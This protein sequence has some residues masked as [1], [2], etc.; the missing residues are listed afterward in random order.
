MIIA[1]Q[2]ALAALE[3]LSAHTDHPVALHE[4]AARLG[5]SASNCARIL[6]T[7]VE[8]GY[9]EQVGR[10]KGY[11]LG[12]VAYA[13]ARHGPYRKDLV[14]AA[15]PFVLGLASALRETASLAVLR[16]GR[17]VL[18]TECDGGQEVQ[19]RGAPGQN[20]DPYLT[21]G[22]RLLL[23]HLAEGDLQAFLAQAGLPAREL[24]PEA[25]R[26]DGLRRCLADIRAAGLA[27]RVRPEVVGLAVPVNDDTGVCA[28]LGVFLPAYRF[29]EE[30]RQEVLVRIRRAAQ[31]LSGHL[32]ARK[33]AL[34]R[35]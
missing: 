1:V 17:R 24:W 33:P 6:Q 23:A 14:V 13:L 22:G 3:V 31:E 15:E 9:A 34:V 5:L 20:Y 11:I 29:I 7:L 27:M 25:A 18:L 32:Q 8:T 26:E 4:L 28:A 21:A 10:K 19:A 12:P 30:H 35:S 16:H 2:K